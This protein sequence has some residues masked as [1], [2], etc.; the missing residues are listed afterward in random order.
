M[1]LENKVRDKAVKSINISIRIL[2]AFSNDITTLCGIFCQALKDRNRQ[3]K[4]ICI[5]AVSYASKHKNESAYYYD[6]SD[7]LFSNV[8]IR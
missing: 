6:N 4:A 3:A 7:D 8:F 5:K 1:D 2:Q